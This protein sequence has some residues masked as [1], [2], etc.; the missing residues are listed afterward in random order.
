MDENLCTKIEK[1]TAFTWVS[2]DGRPSDEELAR[3]ALFRP[4][5]RQIKHFTYSPL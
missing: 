2:D 5:Y 3:T 4:T 1:R